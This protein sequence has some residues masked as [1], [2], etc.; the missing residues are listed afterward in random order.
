MSAQQPDT[1]IARSDPDQ[2]PQRPPEVDADLLLGAHPE[3]VIRH[4]S[5]AYRLRRTRQDKL[6]LTK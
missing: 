1:G 5:E 6:I 4:G 3:V 2:Q